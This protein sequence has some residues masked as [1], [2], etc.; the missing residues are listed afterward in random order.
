MKFQALSPSRAY[1]TRYPASTNSSPSLFK[2]VSSASAKSNS[3]FTA[4]LGIIGPEIAGGSAL[5]GI[6]GAAGIAVG[7]GTG[8][9]LTAVGVGVGAG[10]AGAG[11]G[12]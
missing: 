8:A 7:G 3:A 12:G 1:Q 4:V 10:R 9:G 11:A 2:K 5:G 6:G